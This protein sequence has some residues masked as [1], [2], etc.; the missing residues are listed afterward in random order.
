MKK[1][2][3]AATLLLLS[4]G[5]IASTASWEGF[6]TGANIGYG[7]GHSQDHSN[8]D[9][10]KQ[11]IK[12]IASGIQLGHNWQFEN[13]IV[14]GVEGGLSLNDIKKDWKDRDNNQYSPYYGK[15]SIKQSGSFN[16]KI[17]Y[18]IEQFLPYFTAGVTIA[19]EEYSLGCDKSL[20]SATNGCKIS[21]Y[22][23]NAS[24][25]AAGANVGAGIMYKF[26][27]NLSGG[28]EYLYTNLGSNSVYLSD[29]NYP[30]VGERNFKTDFSTTTVKLNY[31]F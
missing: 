12:G 2:L 30:S 25:I 23:T 18:A 6:Y 13:N 8:S 15:N 26:N 24:N 11:D 4:G 17:G 3:L 7:W 16:V 21:E 22:N 31:H 27:D 29:P 10:V 28:I 1:S 9:A 20:V 19:K 14:L 5:A